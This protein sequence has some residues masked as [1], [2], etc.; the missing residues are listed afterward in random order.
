MINDP[1]YNLFIQKVLENGAVTEFN[2]DKLEENANLYVILKSGKYLKLIET[3]IIS[4][5]IKKDFPHN[6][7]LVE[8]QNIRD[9]FYLG[10]FNL[11]DFNVYS[12]SVSFLSNPQKCFYEKSDAMT[13][14]DNIQFAE[15]TKFELAN[16]ELENYIKKIIKKSPPEEQI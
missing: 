2:L 7:V 9:N 5:E 6:D 15:E 14:I 11:R 12:D 10:R 13:Y 3:T 8:L 16:S 4:I 1:S